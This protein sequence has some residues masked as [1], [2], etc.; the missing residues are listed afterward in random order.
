MMLL[1]LVL[2]FLAYR[3]LMEALAIVTAKVDKQLTIIFARL[4]ANLPDVESKPCVTKAIEGEK[5]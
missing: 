3:H 1:R 2:D 5:I 4:I